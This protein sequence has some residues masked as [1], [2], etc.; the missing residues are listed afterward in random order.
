MP[1]QYTVEQ[2][3]EAAKK[4]GEYGISDEKMEEIFLNTVVEDEEDVVVA[5]LI[6]E[7]HRP[8][9]LKKLADE[10]SKKS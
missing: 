1:K 3:M 2:M 9:L 6:M 4:T 8:T 10:H 5:L 7:I